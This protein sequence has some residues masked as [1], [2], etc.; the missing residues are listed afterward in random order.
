M[1]LSG[2]PGRFAKL[3]GP[4]KGWE[5]SV[6]VVYSFLRI[7]LRYLKKRKNTRCGEERNM[8][9]PLDCG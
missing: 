8:R 4:L 7:P 2:A 5:R 6:H 1:G 3:Q 9:S